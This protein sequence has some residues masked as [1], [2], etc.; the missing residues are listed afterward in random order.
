M[1]RRGG[2]GASPPGHDVELVDDL[3]LGKVCATGFGPDEL[4]LAGASPRGAQA[5]AIGR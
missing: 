5:Y 3:S 2:G 4:V 1:L